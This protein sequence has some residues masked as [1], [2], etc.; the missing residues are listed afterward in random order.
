MEVQQVVAIVVEAVGYIQEISG[1]SVPEIF[2]EDT[3]PH[4]D[5]E[6]FDS[7]NGAEAAAIIAEKC[8][9]NLDSNPFAKGGRPLSIGVIAKNIVEIKDGKNK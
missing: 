4:K 7:L 6:C 9:V 8:G 1:R 3:V 5:C 2:S